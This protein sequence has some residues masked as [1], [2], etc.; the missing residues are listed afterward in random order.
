MKKLLGMVG[1]AAACGVCCAFPLALPLLGGTITSSLGIVFGWKG[2]A[3]A[4]V[5]AVVAL[6]VVLRRRQARTAACTPALQDSAAGCGCAP[7]K[8]CAT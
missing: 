3:L 6:A 2:A 5:A 7:E 8:R 1:L 4:G